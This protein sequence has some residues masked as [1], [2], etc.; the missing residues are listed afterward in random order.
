[1]AISFNLYLTPASL[2]GLPAGTAFGEVVPG[3]LPVHLPGSDRVLNR[4]INLQW[5]F[6]SSG[7]QWLKES[8]PSDFLLGK[9]GKG[10]M[11]T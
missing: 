7:M 2:E 3:E 11:K 10:V 5:S 9:G 8:K 6:Q 4:G 1:M